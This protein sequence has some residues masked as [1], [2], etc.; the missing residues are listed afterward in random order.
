M[1]AYPECEH[2]H[3][4]PNSECKQCSTADEIRDLKTELKEMKEQMEFY[5]QHCITNKVSLVVSQQ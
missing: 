5:R 3:K 2:G 4:D 1:S